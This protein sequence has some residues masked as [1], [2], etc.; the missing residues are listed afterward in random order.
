MSKPINRTDHLNVVHQIPGTKTGI[1]YDQNGKGVRQMQCPKCKS[2]YVRP[3]RDGN[4]KLLYVCGCGARWYS[5]R[6]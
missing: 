1:V 5:N 2:S 4:N 6:M 3:Q